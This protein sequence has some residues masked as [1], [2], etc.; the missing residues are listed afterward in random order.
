MEL[1]LSRLKSYLVFSALIVVIQWFIGCSY[2]KVSQYDRPI[3]LADNDQFNMRYTYAEVTI[4]APILILDAQPTAYR[5][6]IFDRRNTAEPLLQQVFF[7]GDSIKLVLPRNTLSREPLGNLAVLTPLGGDFVEVRHTFSV[8][9]DPRIM[10]PISKVQRI[11]YVLFGTVYRRADNTPVAGA[12]V[13]L[14]DSQHVFATSI[15]DTMGFYRMQLRASQGEQEKL[16]LTVDTKGDLPKL[17]IPFNFNSDHE[18]RRDLFLGPPQTFLEKG[19]PYRVNENLVPFREGPEN[20]A[21]VHFFLSKG[22]LVIVSKVA[23][24]RLFGLTEIRDETRGTTQEVEGWVLNRY[25]SPVLKKKPTP[26][27]VATKKEVPKAPVE[28]LPPS[29]PIAR[30]YVPTTFTSVPAEADILLDGNVIGTTPLVNYPVEA[31]DHEVTIVKE[32]YAPVT[33]T[34]QIQPAETLTIEVKLSPF[35]PV[36]FYSRE[37]SLTFVLDGEYRWQDKK[38]KLVMEAGTHH[39]QVYKLKELV[40]EQT[41]T[42]NQKMKITYELIETSSVKD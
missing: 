13:S 34:I 18:V 40:D 6:S 1:L 25:V 31:G 36:K 33:K 27:K 11:P 42:V 20:G 30:F 8:T 39:L 32:D 17:S 41:F 2:L 9:P 37:D 28:I 5:L 15:S 16:K 29:A 7:P 26:K 22:D 35:Y 10:L 3:I 24:D 38:I 12:E 4:V 19:V 14:A 21:P 23:G